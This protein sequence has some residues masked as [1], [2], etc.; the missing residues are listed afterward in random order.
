MDREQHRDIHIQAREVVINRDKEKER[1]TEGG[2]GER[3][4]CTPYK[5]IWKYS[6]NN[7][8]ISTKRT[9]REQHRDIH[10]K[11]LSQGNRD[12]EKERDG[13][14]QICEGADRYTIIERERRDIMSQRRK[15]KRERMDW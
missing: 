10:I 2:E 4:R 9:D 5:H 12:K 13:H 1:E 11:V 8:K 3:E 15:H 6:D 7:F 14:V